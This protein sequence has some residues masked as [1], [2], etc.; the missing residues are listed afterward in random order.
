MGKMKFYNKKK[1]YRNTW[2]TVDG[3][4]NWRTTEVKRWCQ[5]NGSR[6]R[7]YF[8]INYP[9]HYDHGESRPYW[10]WYFENAQDATAFR[11][12]WSGNV[13]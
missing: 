13:K 6:D 8:N 1:E 2:I 7:F 4:V 12:M 3:P 11:L 5:Q 9:R 10:P